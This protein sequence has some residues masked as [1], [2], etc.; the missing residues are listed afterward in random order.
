MHKIDIILPFYKPAPGWGEH[1]RPKMAALQEH[2]QGRCELFF[3][4][5][6][7][8]SAMTYFP[9]E[10]FQVI[11]KDVPNLEFHSYPE[12]HGKGYC[13]RFGVQKCTCEYQVYTDNDFP[14]G[15]ESV[16]AVIDALLDGADV[17][18]GQRGDDYAKALTLKRKIVSAGVRFMN[19]WI[20]GLPKEFLDAQAGV[21]GFNATGRKFFLAT[22]TDS[23]L[24]DT[25]FIALA[26]FARPK[27][28]IRT[29]PVA[30][31]PSV[32]FSNMGNNTLWRELKHFF[33]VFWRCRFHRQKV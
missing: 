14:F 25:E 1:V 6:N 33:R 8:G 11:R 22:T 18:M 31:Q 23:Y 10:E 27:V 7:D 32:R 29:V 16:S 13:L 15:W 26:S 3:H 20:M 28:D 4:I 21:K 17:V 2:F 30:L 5:V 19:R 9:D 24:F 12:N